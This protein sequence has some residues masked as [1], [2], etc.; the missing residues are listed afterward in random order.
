MNEPP[1]IRSA[2]PTFTKI[3]LAHPFTIGKGTIVDVTLASVSV[4]AGDG[5]REEEGTGEVF[6]TRACSAI[7]GFSGN[8]L[9]AYWS[10]FPEALRQARSLN[11]V[12]PNPTLAVA[13]A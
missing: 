1:E 7:E 4:T 5:T 13:N 12:A 9:V 6:L 2:V 10:L 3:L 8:P 11:P